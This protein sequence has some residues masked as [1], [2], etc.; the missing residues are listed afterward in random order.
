MIEVNVPLDE[1]YASSS[2][3]VAVQAGKKYAAYTKVAGINGEPHTAFF[4]V[5]L[6]DG[7]DE[8][9]KRKVVWLDDFSG[10]EKEYTI[11]FEAP[12]RCEKIKVLY[13]I[14]K[15]TSTKSACKFRIT[16][17]KEVI[18]FERDDPEKNNL[19]IVQ[20][21]PRAKD[22]S[23]E[24]ESI[25]EQNIVWI[26]GARR[27][28][29]TWLGK[30][31]LSYSTYYVHEPEISNHLAVGAN[32]GTG[33]FVRRIDFRKDVAGYFFSDKYK[34]TWQ[35]FL[36]KLILYR[37]NAQVKDT[38]KKI[39][40]KEPSSGL[41]ASDIIS[42]CMPNSK[43]IVLFR[44]GRDIIDSLRDKRQHGGWSNKRPRR[45]MKDDQ[46]L[47][48]IKRHARVWVKQMEVLS[49]T[50]RLHDQ[51]LTFVLRYEDLLADTA[52][53]VGKIYHFL[54]IHIPE[55][56]LQRLIEQFRFEN[57]PEDQR[58]EG[59]FYRSGTSGKWKDNF[60]EE[61]VEVVQEIMGDMLQKLGY[62]S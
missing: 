49:T 23:Q 32:K 1:T 48:F 61:E 9:I 30:Q 57:I 45:K 26:F 22:L 33:E 44:D 11:E 7:N 8:V 28:G 51:N 53:M 52:N 55:V 29:T 20:A 36:R 27:S 58:G 34:N 15:D 50:A 35:P 21:L 60:S 6:F 37:I 25:L 17:I 18:V 16:P 41:D 5:A 62:S 39:I 31:L 40:V 42:S 14:N 47:A 19:N 2:N 4:G 24:E 12:N 43:V 59:K 56:E 54:G 46:R 13:R 38:S 10:T 3:T